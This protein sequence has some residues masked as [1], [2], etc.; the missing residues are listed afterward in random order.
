MKKV[1]F[2]FLVI[3]L[4]PFV[5]ACKTNVP[6]SQLDAVITLEGPIE[7]SIDQKNWGTVLKDSD[8]DQYLANAYPSFEFIPIT[9]PSGKNP[10]YIVTEEGI[11]ETDL[12][13]LEIPIFIRSEEPVIIQWKSASLSSVPMSWISDRDFQSGASEV[14]IGEE[15]YSTI[16]NAIRISITG[17]INEEEQTITYERPKGYHHNNVL[18]NGGNYSQEEKGASGFLSYYYALNQKELYGASQVVVAPSITDVRE[19]HNIILSTI[20][21]SNEMM[22]ELTIRIWVER[23][24]PD[25][26][27][28][29][30]NQNFSLSFLFIGK[31]KN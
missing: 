26:Y 31:L 12:G 11:E 19:S 27:P 15:T 16:S 21:H 22:T 18:G 4:L 25:S 7:I 3:T 2:Y 17:S 1:C 30:L 14:S 10:F 13:Y 23:W 8:F 6:F 5:S 24:D 28:V 29:I 20:E 9:T